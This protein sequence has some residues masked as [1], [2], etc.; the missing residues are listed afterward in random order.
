M[1]R[2]TVTQYANQ[3]KRVLCLASSTTSDAMSVSASES[4]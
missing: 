2:R 4:A 3:I 1:G